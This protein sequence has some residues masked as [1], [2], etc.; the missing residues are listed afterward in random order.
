M[1]KHYMKIGRPYKRKNSTNNVGL[2]PARY[3][4]ILTISRK[5]IA[6]ESEVEYISMTD[7]DAVAL[8][9]EESWLNR[10]YVELV[11]FI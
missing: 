2:K 6:N 4:Y 1:W 8:S 7:P 11:G 3:E 9:D 10:Q 5:R